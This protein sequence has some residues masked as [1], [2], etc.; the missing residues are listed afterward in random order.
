MKKYKFV[1]IGL[2]ALFLAAIIIKGCDGGKPDP[3]IVDTSTESI[4]TPVF[5]ADSAYQYVKRQV[6]FGPRVPNTAE[7]KKCGDYL[8]ASLRNFGATVIE[9]TTKVK[10]WNGTTLDIRNIIGQYNPS[11]KRRIIL[12]AHWDT[13][14]Y[15]DKD[16]LESNHRKPIDGANDGASGVGIL[17]EIARALQMEPMIDKIGIDIIL[18]DGEDY[19]KPEFEKNRFDPDSD[20]EAAYNE[21]QNDMMTWCL[22]SQYWSQNLHVGGYRAQYAILLDMVGARHAKFYQEGYSIKYAPD[23]VRKVWGAASKAGYGEI[24]SNQQVGGIFDDHLPINELAGIRAI[25]IVQFGPTTQVMGLQTDSE[26]ETFGFYHHTVFDNMDIIDKKTLEA[27]GQTVLN[28][29]YSEK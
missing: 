28:V 22:G 23:I 15:A 5:S 13:R 25:N 26:Q 6:D 17:L 8:A 14:P 1:A 24:F 20:S 18:F 21:A 29:I 7:H 19:G 4:V 16:S 9:Q 12:C 3:V 11:A 10:A 27:V 2:L